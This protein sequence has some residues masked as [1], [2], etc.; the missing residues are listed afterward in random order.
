MAG[1]K[2]KKNSNHKNLILEQSSPRALRR[3]E[4]NHSRSCAFRGLLRV[5]PVREKRKNIVQLA[6]DQLFLWVIRVR[7]VFRPIRES[8]KFRGFRPFPPEIP[9]DSK[10]NRRFPRFFKSP[11][12]LRI[13]PKI[14]SKPCKFPVF[15]EKSLRSRRNRGLMAIVCRPTQR[16]PR[17]FSRFAGVFFAYPVQRVDGAG[18][19]IS[20]P[21]AEKGN[22]AGN[23][24]LRRLN[25]KSA[26]GTDTPSPKDSHV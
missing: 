1:L 4:E 9:P 8:V 11:E 7:R 22:H 10:K 13:S 26:T 3:L 24:L 17:H 16:T 5:R 20:A 23:P 14:S 12:T 18:R 25:R 19:D 15:P 6:H 2:P 21:S